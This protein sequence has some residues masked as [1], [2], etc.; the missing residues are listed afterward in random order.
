MIGID[1]EGGLSAAT[2]KHNGFE[3]VCRYLS[4]PD[5]SKNLTAAEVADCHANGVSIVTVF[6]TGGRMDGG[7]QQG[8]DDAHL[9]MECL[10]QLKAPA[11]TLVYFAADYDV[12]ADQLPTMG[13]YLLGTHQVFDPATVGIYGGL[14]AVSYALDNHLVAKA[15]Q[16][17]AWSPSWDSRAVLRQYS[18]GHYIDGVQVDY[19]QATTANYGQWGSSITTEKDDIVDYVSMSTV[20]NGTKDSTQSVKWQTIRD[21]TQTYHQAGDFA[22]V[23][24]DG[25][26]TFFNLSL[27]AGPGVVTL[28]EVDPKKNYDVTKTYSHYVANGSDIVFNGCV[29]PGKHLWAQVTPSVSGPYGVGVRCQTT[30]RK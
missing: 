30:A 22:I 7:Y 2:I 13:Q 27:S 12:S 10:D 28:V 5:E 15:W 3:F 26:G 19:D 17:L 6:E 23:Q 14:R 18:N 24:A 9:A 25:K 16:T 11:G 20:V 1:Y 21:T 4:H 29:S 8:I